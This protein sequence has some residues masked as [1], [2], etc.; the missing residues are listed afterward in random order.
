MDKNFVAE[1]KAFMERMLQHRSIG[2]KLERYEPGAEGSAGNLYAR[3]HHPAGDIAYEILKN[4][5]SKLNTPKNTDFDADYYKTLKEAQL[6]AQSKQAKLW[7]DFKL[8]GA[9]EEKKQQKPSTTDFTGRVVEI[10]SG[11]SLTVERD[12]DFQ[13][14]RVYL[15]TVKAP[16]LMKKQ[17]EEAD[18]WAWD[19]KEALRKNAIGKKVRV[20]ME[21]SRTVKAGEVDRNMDFA[22]VLMDKS[23]K[24]LSTLLLEKGLLKT[25]I[26]KSGDNAS[27]FIED[28]LAAERKAQEGKLGVYSTAPAPIRIFNDLVQNTKKAKDFEAMVM[29]RP[30]RKMS[31]VVEYCFSGMRFKVRLD[32]ENTAIA[33]NLLGVRTMAN[34]KNQPKMLELSNDAQQFAKDTL[35]QRDVTVDLEFADKRGSFFGTVSLKNTKE[36]FGLMLVE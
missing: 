20:I 24:N 16:I 36:D 10:H 30:S 18:P 7:K 26:T 28:L 13:L 31:G 27:K 2:V 8:G 19:S 25:N 9:G 6:I 14:I 1:G 4:G 15:A 12:G 29:K 32:G 34:D 17:G 35:F 23:D 3:V 33:L 21:F 11:D 5:F 22:T